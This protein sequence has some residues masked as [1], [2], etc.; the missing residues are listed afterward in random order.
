MNLSE[1]NFITVCWWI[2]HKN[3]VLAVLDF[4]GDVLSV[5]PAFDYSKIY[6]PVNMVLL[7]STELFCAWIAAP[8]PFAS[9]SAMSSL[10]EP[11][12]FD[13]LPSMNTIERIK[14]F[15]SGACRPRSDDMGMGHCWIEGRICSSSNSCE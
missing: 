8:P 10:E 1:D 14:S 3:I 4:N 12:G 15:S 11:L 2:Q 13:K 7:K 5:L 9:I 6:Y